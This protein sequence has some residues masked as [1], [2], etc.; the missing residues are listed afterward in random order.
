MKKLIIFLIPALFLLQPLKAA[1]N[2]ESMSLW[3]LS[4]HWPTTALKKSYAWIMQT[5][6]VWGQLL[7]G[8]KTLDKISHHT[9]CIVTHLGDT[10]SLRTVTPIVKEPTA[11]RQMAHLLEFGLR[12]P[13]APKI[14]WG[15][16]VTVSQSKNS[17][18]DEIPQKRS[19]AGLRL[20]PDL[21]TF[22]IGLKYKI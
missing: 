7:N 6:L 16:E 3:E 1:Q 19:W 2:L 12:I 4:T 9:P 22:Q 21:Y 5:S 20:K 14:S 17:S 11:K 13:L 10:W 15:A 8:F 18:L